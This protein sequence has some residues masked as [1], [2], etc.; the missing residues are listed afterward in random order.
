MRWHIDI[1]KL[2]CSL[3]RWSC[4]CVEI[5]H[6]SSVWVLSQLSPCAIFS[7]HVGALHYSTASPK[8]RLLCRQWQGLQQTVILLNGSVYYYCVPIT[9][10]ESWRWHLQNTKASCVVGYKKKKKKHLSKL[11][12][13]MFVI[14]HQAT[15]VVLIVI[16]R[17]N[18]LIM[19]KLRIK[20]GF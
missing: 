4:N 2:Y 8:C 13:N 15:P 14:D 9:N 18:L 17:E 5:I 6:T 12:Q 11:N 10:A 16:Y 19:L 1:W 3:F 7:S 20:K